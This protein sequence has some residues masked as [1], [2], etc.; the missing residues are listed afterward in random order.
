[1]IDRMKEKTLFRFITNIGAWAKREV[2]F[3]NSCHSGLDPV[4][5]KEKGSETKLLIRSKAHSFSMLFK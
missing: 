4:H 5:L 2:L 3:I 1:M